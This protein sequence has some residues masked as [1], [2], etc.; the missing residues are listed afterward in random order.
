MLECLVISKK[1]YK[2][3]ISFFLTPPTCLL[4]DTREPLL[5][6]ERIERHVSV[7]GHRIV[8]AALIRITANV[9]RLTD[10]FVP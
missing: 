10:L 3:L 2:N 1:N 8:V 7:E 5:V 9:V 4:L 6:F